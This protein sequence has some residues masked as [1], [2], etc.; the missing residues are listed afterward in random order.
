LASH[1]GSVHWNQSR[2]VEKLVLKWVM[3]KDRNPEHRD[4]TV[5]TDGVAETPLSSALVAHCVAKGLK[6]SGLSLLNFTEINSVKRHL[7][8]RYCSNTLPVASNKKINIQ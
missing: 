5:R 3:T 1:V 6:Y 4:S 2:E 7:F 8:S